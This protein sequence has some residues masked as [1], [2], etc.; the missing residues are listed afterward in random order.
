MDYTV[1]EETFWTDSKVVLGCIT[2]EARRFH[3]FVANRVQRIRHS[4]TVEQWKYIPTG[5]NPT[6][7]ASRGLTV[8]ELL[9]SNWFVGSTFL[10]EKEMPIPAEPVPDLLLG[11][12]EVKTFCTLNTNCTENFYLVDRLSKFSSWSK[13]IRAVAHLLRRVNKDKSSHPSTVSEGHIAELY[14]IKCLQESSYKVRVE[15]NKGWKKC[16]VTQ[17]IVSSWPFFR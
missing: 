14:I 7:H 8:R 5:E 16:L 3:T 15:I 2:N 4:T 13:A 12:P 10:W 17:C 11:A 9:A 1:I 6:D